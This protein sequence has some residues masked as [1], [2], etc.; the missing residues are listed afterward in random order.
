MLNWIVGERSFL[1]N[2]RRSSFLV[3]FKVAIPVK[4]CYFVIGYILMINILNSE[5]F[6]NYPKLR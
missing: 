4:L 2:L 5:V 1:E 6:P 3:G